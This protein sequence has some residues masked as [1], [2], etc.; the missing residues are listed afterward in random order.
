METLTA[1]RALAETGPIAAQE[2][3]ALDFVSHRIAVSGGL[4]IDARDYA[5][6]LPETGLPVICLH[7]LTRNARDFEI[8][9]PRIAAL[10]R[11]T[12]ALT[13]RGRGESDYDPD[14]SHYA[15]PIYVADVI[16]AMDA[17]DVHRAVFVGTSMGGIVTMALA[18]GARDR[19]AGAVLNDVGPV[20]DPAGL[21]RIGAYVGKGGLVAT[22][23]AAAAAAK[24]VNATAF[25]HGDAAFWDAFAR[26]T[27]RVR[28]D[29]KIAPDYDP[30]IAQAFAAP[31]DSNATPADMSPLFQ[32]LATAPVL[33]VRGA[34]S[35]LLAPAGIAAMRGVKSDLVVAEVPGIGHAPM[36]DEPAAWD[37]L[38]DF[39]AKIP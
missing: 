24:A 39:L 28:P 31:P 26:R 6:T 23:S 18:Y 30:A 9:A 15:P 3:A 34:I 25:P 17:L 33:V 32:A 22:W 8:V 5:P 7:G 12:I 35:D 2:A 10:G 19:V 29:G 14:P 27:F 11:R 21:A 1:P 20:L 36:L 4:S 37:A 13:M 38:L 16:A